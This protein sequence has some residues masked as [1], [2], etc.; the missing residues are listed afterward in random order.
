MRL[1]NQFEN[2]AI[3]SFFNLGLLLLARSELIC[4]FLAIRN[5]SE[6]VVVVL[7]AWDLEAQVQ[8]GVVEHLLVVACCVVGEHLHPGRPVLVC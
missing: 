6:W 4:E 1:I 7:G 3:D 5:F 8:H 2:S